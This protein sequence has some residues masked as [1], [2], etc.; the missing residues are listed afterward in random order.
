MRSNRNE[1]RQLRGELT[2][3]VS[4]GAAAEH[5]AIIPALLASFRERCH[6][7]MFT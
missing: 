2:G 5:D 6:V 3:Q 7:S 1:M 4:L